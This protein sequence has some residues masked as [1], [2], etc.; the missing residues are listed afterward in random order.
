MTMQPALGVL[1]RAVLLVEGAGC[2]FVLAALLDE[3]SRLPRGL[4]RERWHLWVFRGKLRLLR[5]AAER[6]DRR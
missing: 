4:V 5:V 6:R 2:L 1:L 3:L